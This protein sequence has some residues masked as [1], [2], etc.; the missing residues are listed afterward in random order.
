MTYRE[1]KRQPADMEAEKL[2]R[3][4]TI[5]TMIEGTD[6]VYNDPI[7][8]PQVFARVWANVAP[9][10][11]REFNDARQIS[12][13]VTTRFH[14]RYL[15]GLKAT[16]TVICDGKTYDIFRIEPLG[17]NDRLNIFGKAREE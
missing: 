3:L 15:A 12:A 14:I 4:I 11:G 9:W 16:M 1:M 8:T 7:E 10:Q 6:P 13:E 5:Q 17:R 2:D